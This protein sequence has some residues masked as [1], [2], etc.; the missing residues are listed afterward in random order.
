ML[1]IGDDNPRRRFPLINYALIAANVLVFLIELN[2]GDNFVYTYSFTPSLFHANPASYF[3]TIITSTFLHAGW[4]HLLGNMLFLWI[5]GDNV[6]D[7]LGHMGYLVFYLVCGAAATLAQYAAA[8][9]A[10]IIVLGASGSI[11]G[12]MGA[13]IVFFPGARVRVLVTII[14]VRVPAW[15]AIGIWIALQVL[16]GVGTFGGDAAAGG[17]AYLA[18]VGGFFT[19]AFIALLANQ[20]HE[21]I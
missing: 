19:G 14:P 1:P 9:N 16:S 10:E 5:F 18:H 20:Q 17:V 6:E 11:A 13:Y 8:P 12:V 3:L 4:L 21:V 15:I 2:F 7:R